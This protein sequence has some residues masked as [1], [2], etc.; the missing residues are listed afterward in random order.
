MKNAAY[1]GP[2][3]EF[4]IDDETYL[5]LCRMVVGEG[6]TQCSPAAMRTMFYALANR[7]LLHPGRK[8]WASF[9]TMLRAFSQPINPAWYKNGSK[10]RAYIAKYGKTGACASARFR[11]RE[12]ISTMPLE[13]IPVE[14]RAEVQDFREGRLRIPSEIFSVLDKPLL[15][16]WGSYKGVER[17]YPGGIN[18]DGNYFFEDNKL[19]Q[20]TWRVVHPQSQ[21]EALLS[22]FMLLGNAIVLSLR[23]WDRLLAVKK[24][25]VVRENAKDLADRLEKILDAMRED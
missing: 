9:L 3:K 4:E 15:S 18:I 22:S 6:G 20:Q 21:T 24:I 11:R 17:R 1:K 7:Y 8:K 25:D 19:L 23:E 5:W 12:M 2:D 16:N 14:I 13:K 10:A